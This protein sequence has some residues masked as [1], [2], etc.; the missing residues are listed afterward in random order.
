MTRF[1]RTL[2]TLLAGL[3]AAAVAAACSRGE[4]G[5]VQ[6]QSGDPV[7]SL[8]EGACNGTCPVYDLTVHANGTYILNG[9][10]FVK[11]TGVSEG[12]IGADAF[13]AAVGVLEDAGFWTMRPVQTMETLQN[14]QTDAPTVLVTWR[15]DSGKEKTVAYNAGCG[16]RKT[17]EMI[18]RLRTA[19]KF[20]D[21]VWTD[22]KFDPETGER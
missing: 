8:S 7:V 11:T 3:V 16:V 4:E 5:L 14:C 21:L 17:Q 20:D 1:R 13:S 15:E 2:N 12:D 6:G 22:A 10:R 9:Q 18:S 19:L